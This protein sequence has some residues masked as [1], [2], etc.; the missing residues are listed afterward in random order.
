VEVQEQ[1]RWLDVAVEDA[2]GVG[3][4]EG[5]GDLE[6]DAGDAPPVVPRRAG[7]ARGLV[8]AGEAARGTRAVG[9]RRGAGGGASIGPGRLAL[10]PLARR[11]WGPAGLLSS[12]GWPGPAA[13][14]AKRPLNS[15]R[16]TSVAEAATVPARWLGG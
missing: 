13:G 15:S 4:V 6:A 3:V 14:A 5:L 16:A 1:V 12:P 9:R 11:G 2:L 10:G 7:E 8:M